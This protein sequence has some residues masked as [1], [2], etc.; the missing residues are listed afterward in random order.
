MNTTAAAITRTSGHTTS[1]LI[2]LLSLSIHVTFA[3]DYEYVKDKFGN[4]LG[5]DYAIG[6]LTLSGELAIDR[7]NRRLLFI[8]CDKKTV[9][10]NETY[11][12]RRT[13]DCL[14]NFSTWPSKLLAH[15]SPSKGRIVVLSG[16]PRTCGICDEIPFLD[17]A[18][19][20]GVTIDPKVLT[21]PADYPR[22]VRVEFEKQRRIEQERIMNEVL[23]SIAPEILT[24]V[25]K[26]F[27]YQRQLDNW[28]FETP[29]V[30]SFNGRNGNVSP[31]G[32]AGPDRGPAGG[33]PGGPGGGF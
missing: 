29:D 25:P 22:E 31:V 30:R 11:M 5:I 32:P 6:D 17:F 12:R 2:L 26:D 7:N 9:L 16:P 13:R 24:P 21:P 4:K 1:I 18:I 3:G 10:D 33:P 20:E 27:N 28:I 19:P 14:L 8:S 23:K 15:I